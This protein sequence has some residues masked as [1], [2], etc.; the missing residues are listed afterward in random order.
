MLSGL[1]KMTKMRKTLLLTF[2]ATSGQ[3]HDTC[4]AAAVPSAPYRS[5]QLEIEAT[6]TIP[7]DSYISVRNRRMA[8]VA[9]GIV[10]DNN[11]CL[12]SEPLHLHTGF[13]QFSDVRR[14]PAM[15]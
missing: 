12:F 11:P 9:G 10:S 14:T 6:R 7:T 15:S 4:C 1:F 13:L 5:L 3:C 8:L 2:S